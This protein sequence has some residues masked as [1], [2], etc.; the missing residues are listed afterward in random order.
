MSAA[1]CVVNVLVSQLSMRDVYVCDPQQGN[2]L[3][4]RMLVLGFQLDRGQQQEPFFL[5]LQE[6]HFLSCRGVII[7]RDIRLA[8]ICR[9]SLTLIFTTF[10]NTT[11]VSNRKDDWYLQVCKESPDLYS[12]EFEGNH[13]TSLSWFCRVLSFL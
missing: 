2:N 5:T 12:M 4:E 10:K 6:A 3:K 9:Q 8:K 1:V 7:V 11:K 13:F